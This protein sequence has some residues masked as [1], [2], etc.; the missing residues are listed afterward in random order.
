M[1]E[2]NP[3]AKTVTI[4]LSRG[5]V[6]KLLIGLDVLAYDIASDVEASKMYRAIHCLIK[7]Q[8]DDHD[9]KEAAK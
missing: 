1:L 3:N 4:K 8:L 5:A 9:A 2:N 7:M 6:C